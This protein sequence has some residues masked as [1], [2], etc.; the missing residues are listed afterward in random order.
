MLST[1]AGPATMI[2]RTSRRVR[3]VIRSFVVTSGAGVATAGY[4]P[5]RGWRARAMTR[6][7]RCGTAA[8]YFRPGVS[9]M[10]L[11]NRV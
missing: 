11:A 8:W 9:Q 10:R 1:A 6:R 5:S 7:Y 3:I 4:P 2:V